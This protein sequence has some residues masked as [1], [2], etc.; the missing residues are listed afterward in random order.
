ERTLD[1]SA[2]RRVVLPQA[3]LSTDAILLI[4]ANITDGLVVNREVISSHVQ[5]QLPFM[6]TENILMEAVKQGADRQ[7]VHEVIRE[8]SHQATTKLKA[9]SRENPL[10]ELLA[11]DSRIPL[12]RESIEKIL[13]PSDFVGRAP[14]QVKEFL[15]KEIDPILDSYE[16]LLDGT[17]TNLFV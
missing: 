4:Y 15:R 12:N 13:K 6:A 3:F 1:D 9:G 5:E 17:G 11:E 16:E 14:N 7:E 10:I 8:Y 2:N